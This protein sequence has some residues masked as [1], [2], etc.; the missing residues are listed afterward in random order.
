MKYDIFN[1]ELLYARAYFSFF[2]VFTIAEKSA[3]LLSNFGNITFLQ[4]F[5]HNFVVEN[6]HHSAISWNVNFIII[7][8]VHCP[9]LQLPLPHC[10]ELFW[11]GYLCT[12]ILCKFSCLISLYIIVICKKIEKK[13]DHCVTYLI[14]SS[15]WGN[16]RSMNDN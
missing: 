1:R 5:V 14:P 7:R 11:I 6:W 2:V 16:A 4:S 10:C 8:I 9:P 12:C 15:K 13:L 3:Y